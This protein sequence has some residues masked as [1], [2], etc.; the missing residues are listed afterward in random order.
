MLT[1]K[2]NLVIVVSFLCTTLSAQEWKKEKSK[3]GRVVV[4]SRIS[5][6]NKEDGKGI[7]V[8]EYV[9]TAQV[10]TTLAKCIEVIKEFSK[11]SELFEDT[12][13]TKKIKDISKNEWLVYYYI[14]AP[15]PAPNNDCVTR[16]TFTEDKV[17]REATFMGIAAPDEYEMKDVKRM[18]VNEIVYH[19]RIEQNGKVTITVSGKFSPVVDVPNW[20]MNT[21]APEGPAKIVEGIIRLASE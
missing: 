14:D 17:K 20:L 3:D 19:F 16:I 5:Q 21:W 6:P 18:T 12:P 8:I 11:H 2:F 15:W 13:I 1:L 10:N 9:A 7:P 4:E